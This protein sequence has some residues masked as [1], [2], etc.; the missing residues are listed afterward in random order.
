MLFT[1]LTFPL[2]CTLDIEQCGRGPLFHGPFANE[3]IKSLLPRLWK[4]AGG[5]RV[6]GGEASH[7]LP[8][9]TPE[10]LSASSCTRNTQQALLLLSPPAPLL[11]VSSCLFSARHRQRSQ[12]ASGHVYVRRAEPQPVGTKRKKW[13]WNDV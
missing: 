4:G 1:L 8:Q 7:L 5:G 9:Q 6:G 2:R 12:A 11:V 10:H 13:E 3:A